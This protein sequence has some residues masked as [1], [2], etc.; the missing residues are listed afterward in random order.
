VPSKATSEQSTSN[1]AMKMGNKIILPADQLMRLYLDEN[2]SSEEIGRR[3]GCDGLTVITRL[4]E[5]GIPIKPRGWHKLVRRVPDT[6]LNSWPSSELAYVVGLVASDGNLQKRNNCMIFVST[7]RELVDACSTL[8]DL[9]SPHIVVARQDPPRKTSFMLQ[10][11]DYKFRQFLEVR[12]LAPNKTMNIGALDIPDSVFADFVRGEFDGDG[13]WHIG[14]GWRG[15]NYL[16]GKFTSRSQRYLEWLHESI[17]RLTGIEGALQ[18][19]RLIYN[20]KKAEELG[21]WMYYSLA[22]PCLPRKRTTWADWLA[23]GND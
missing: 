21:R 22:V 9:D 7:E 16:I 18:S 6:V 14:K 12:G 10:V 13:G 15:Y 1:R 11:C 17:H 5:Y 8:L 2:L 23:S 4:R 3:F 19:S 20:G